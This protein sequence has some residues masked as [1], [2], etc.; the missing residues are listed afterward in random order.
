MNKKDNL[1]TLSNGVD[2]ECELI[3]DKACENF[4]EWVKN[5]YGYQQDSLTILGNLNENVNMIPVEER[6]TYS[7]SQ[8][9]KTFPLSFVSKIRKSVKNECESLKNLNENENC[10]EFGD[11]QQHQTEPMVFNDESDDISLSS[12]LLSLEIENS[13]TKSD[14]ANGNLLNEKETKF[15]PVNDNSFMN[16]EFPPVDRYGKRKGIIDFGSP[17]G[18][19]DWSIYDYSSPKSVS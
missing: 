4:D 5:V 11:I 10:L 17:I 18:S 13:L 9:S 2:K 12:E 7:F 8:H 15:S 1:S 3:I 19:D 16:N 14:L 6:V